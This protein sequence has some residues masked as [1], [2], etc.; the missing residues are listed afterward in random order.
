MR[1]MTLILI[2]LILLL[3]G[4]SGVQ[5]PAPSG[6]KAP[7]SAA[8]PDDQKN[9]S[10]PAQDDGPKVA[11]MP[12]P[13]LLCLKPEDDSGIV[14]S[15]Y[16]GNSDSTLRIKPGW[17]IPFPANWFIVA[18]KYPESIDRERVEVKVEPAYW[19]Q[20]AR[21][22]PGADTFSFAVLPEGEEK[23]GIPGWITVTVDGAQ[24]PDGK[25]L[26]AEPITFRLWAYEALKPGETLPPCPGL[27]VAPPSGPVPTGEAAERAIGRA[28]A[29]IDSYVRARAAGQPVD[30]LLAAGA[31]V[32]FLDSVKPIQ[33]LGAQPFSVQADHIQ[34]H[35]KVRIERNDG[36]QS[37]AVLVATIVQEGNGWKIQSIYPLK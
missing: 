12:P 1:Q 35:P 2:S 20:E 26:Q 37:D 11:E 27:E 17:T 8:P 10:A 18:V 9:A 29:L 24:S 21:N 33:Y 3:T 30:H 19:E 4:C 23:T 36:T 13:E 32:S 28:A 14:I 16:R 6:E 31:D 25:P 34:I 22:H 7:A 5:G 15:L